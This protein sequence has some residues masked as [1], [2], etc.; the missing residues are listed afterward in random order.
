[1]HSKQLLRRT[2]SPKAFWKVNKCLARKLGHVETILLSELIYQEELAEQRGELTEDGFFSMTM[3]ELEAYTAISES[4]QK[5]FCKRLEKHRCLE[6]ALR[7]IPRQK[8]YRIQHEYIEA[9]LKQPETGQS[10]HKGQNDLYGETKM[11]SQERPNRTDR[12]GQNGLSIP[13]SKKNEEK[14][15]EKRNT[16]SPELSSNEFLGRVL[17]NLQKRMNAPSF[18]TW[19]QPVKTIRMH[20]SHCIIEVPDETFVYWLDTYYTK[21]FQEIIKEVTGQ[22]VTVE[23]RVELPN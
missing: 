23:F 18:T 19:L 20:D 5:R 1:M 12:Q 17:D 13:Y 15:E 3:A 9:M 16:S 14:N 2:L 10:L 22:Q 11:T 7:G 6:T 4:S 21:L 8:Y